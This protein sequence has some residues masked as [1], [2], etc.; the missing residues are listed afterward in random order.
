MSRIVLMGGLVLVSLFVA[1]CSQGDAGPD[2]GPDTD[3]SSETGFKQYGEDLVGEIVTVDL[4]MPGDSEPTSITVEAV[5]GRLIYQGDIVLGD[6][7]MAEHGAI[8]S[9]GIVVRRF[10]SSLW[11][12]GI[13]PYRVSSRLYEEIGP[14]S[15]PIAQHVRDAIRHWE[16]NTPIRFR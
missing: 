11:E 9:Q 8:D 13:V 2:P 16:R 5:D 12:N 7:E 1:G 10:S 14:G 3:L 15:V 6:V 4:I